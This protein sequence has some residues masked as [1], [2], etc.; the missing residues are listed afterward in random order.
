MNPTQSESQTSPAIDASPRLGVLKT[1]KLYIGGKFPR[2]ESGRFY[3]LTSSSGEVLA[4]MCQASRKDFREAVVAARAAQSG[5]SG[6]T[7]YLR[8]QILYRIAEMLE[9]RASQFATELIQMGAEPE[10]ARAE[11]ACAIDRLVYYAGWCDKYQQVFSSVN[12]V[13]SSHFNFSLPEPTGVVS[14]IGP[15]K[16]GLIGLISV[17]AP[18]I[19]AGNTCVALASQSKALCAITLAEVLHTSDL[20]GGVVNLLTGDRDE[21]LEH[22]ASHMDVNATVYCGSDADQIE[23]LR[24]HAAD[25]LKRV[26]TNKCTDWISPDA[27]SPYEMLNTVEVK[28]TWHP[29]GM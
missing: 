25:N 16:N 5:W 4:N 14:V 20:P 10:A 29:I 28:T 21:L 12:P 1:Y 22:F 9:G 6:A 13:A 2:T 26:I 24:T 11:V 23:R 3:K 17:I 19:A 18:I 15:E 7:A 8:G 27:Q